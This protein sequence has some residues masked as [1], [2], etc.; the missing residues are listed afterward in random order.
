MEKKKTSRKKLN[1][2]ARDKKRQEL[3]DLYNRA[4]LHGFQVGEAEGYK[5]GYAEAAEIGKRER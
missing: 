2:E 3:A 5:K 1:K 4:F